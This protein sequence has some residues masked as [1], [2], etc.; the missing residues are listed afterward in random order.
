MSEF[1]LEVRCEEIPAR[2]LQPA[3]REL[4]SRLFEQLLAQGLPRL[5]AAQ[6]QPLS[7]ARRMREVWEETPIGLRAPNLAPVVVWGDLAE[8]ST[9]EL[10]GYLREL[11][12]RPEVAEIDLALR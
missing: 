6:D 4:A 10:F 11:E 3:I 5:S 7:A 12:G 8:P 1:F 2:M 9:R